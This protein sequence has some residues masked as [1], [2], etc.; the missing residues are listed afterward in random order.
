MA[1]EGRLSE[2]SI[3][4]TTECLA[5]RW[6]GGKCGVPCQPRKG[7]VAWAISSKLWSAACSSGF[8]SHKASSAACRWWAG[9]F[10]DSVVPSYLDSLPACFSWA[11]LSPSCWC[12]CGVAGTH[13]SAWTSLGFLTSRPPSCPGSWW[14]SLCSWATPSSSTYWVSQSWWV[15][16]TRALCSCSAL[17]SH[18]CYWGTSMVSWF[19]LISDGGFP[20]VSWLRLLGGPASCLSSCLWP[21]FCY[22]FHSIRSWAQQKPGPLAPQHSGGS[23]DM[24]TQ[25]RDSWSFILLRLPA[26]LGQLAKELQLGLTLL[27]SLPR[28]CSGSHLLFL[29]RCFP[30]PAWRKEVAVNPWLPVSKASSFWDLLCCFAAWI[31]FIANCGLWQHGVTIGHNCMLIAPQLEVYASAAESTGTLHVIYICTQGP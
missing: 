15:L 28:D 8:P 30:Q 27:T 22:V 19:H 2:Q 29:G 11:R 26:A 20:K 7:L 4:A 14:D 5:L 10:L 23:W 1:V 21:V 17:N 18:R 25:L 13:T 24:D 16:G 31:T 9:F 12:M 3:H 6:Q